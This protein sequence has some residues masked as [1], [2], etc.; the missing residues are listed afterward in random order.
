MAIEEYAAR[1]L[2]LLCETAGRQFPDER[3]MLVNYRQIPEVVWEK[4]PG[5]FGFDAGGRGNRADERG[6]GS[7]REESKPAV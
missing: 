6:G 1:I 2:G 5:H 7:R 4:L 3:G